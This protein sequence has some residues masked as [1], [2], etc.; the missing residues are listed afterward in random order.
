ME[1][2][3]HAPKSVLT[4]EIKKF[5]NIDTLSN[6]HIGH[7]KNVMFVTKSLLHKLAQRHVLKLVDISANSK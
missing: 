7:K 2:E 1:D 3:Y 5:E 6:F 4:N